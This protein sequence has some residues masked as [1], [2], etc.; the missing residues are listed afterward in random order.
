MKYLFTRFLINMPSSAQFFLCK[1]IIKCHD[2]VAKKHSAY[3]SGYTASARYSTAHEF[4]FRDPDEIFKEFFGNKDPFEAF[5][6]DKDPFKAFFGNKDP[7]EA[8][9]TAEG[10]FGL[11]HTG[12][13]PI[14][15]FFWG[16]G[17]FYQE[18][19]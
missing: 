3:D 2:F 17:G 13:N 6:G 9:F 8:V 7:F 5:F 10:M 1:I 18:E 14:R 12:V 15:L 4:K 16:G 11:S 19:N